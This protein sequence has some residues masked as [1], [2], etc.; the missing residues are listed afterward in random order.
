MSLNNPLPGVVFEED[1][2]ALGAGQVGGLS[3]T[4]II[5]TANKGDLL[6]SEPI[7]SVNRLE[8][9]F[10]TEDIWDMSGAPTPLGLVRGCK[11]HLKHANEIF[12]IRVASS[13]ASKASYIVIPDKQQYQEITGINAE[14]TYT[15]KAIPDDLGANF[16]ASVDVDGTPAVAVEYDSDSPGADNVALITSAHVGSALPGEIILGANLLAL[17]SGGEIIKVTFYINTTDIQI[18]TLT[19]KSEGTWGQDI[20]LWVE[21]STEQATVEDQSI[22]GAT[23]VV[24]GVA[25]LRYDD[26][27]KSVIN[28]FYMENKTDG[29]DTRPFN[30][31]YYSSDLI[32]YAGELTQSDNLAV[33]NDRV[34][35]VFKVIDAISIE[36]I[37]VRIKGDTAVLTDDVTVEIFA[38]NADEEPTGSA[39]LSL[40][41]D[42][43]D[44]DNTWQNIE[45]VL[46]ATGNELDL[47]ANTKYALVVSQPGTTDVYNIQ[48]VD[49]HV[50]D[51]PHYYTDGNYLNSTD[52]GTT[53]LD[54]NKENSLIFAVRAILTSGQIA[55]MSKSWGDPTNLA[56]TA[57]IFLNSID[58]AV[59]TSYDIHARYKVNPN[60]N[61]HKLIVMLGDYREEYIVLSG[62]DLA[63]DV[64]RES[65]ILDATEDTINY[66]L[67]PSTVN[68]GSEK[69]PERL[70]GG[71]NG[72]EADPAD[73]LEALEIAKTVEGAYFVVIASAGRWNQSD[74]L[75][76][77]HVNL[78]AHVRLMTE[79]GF[80]RKAMCGMRARG[81]G[82]TFGDYVDEIA[83]RLDTIADPNGRLD[84]VGHGIEIT[85]ESPQAIESTVVLPGAMNACL[86]T[87]AFA[88][89]PENRNTTRKTINGVIDLEFEVGYEEKLA[90]VN[91]G[92]V[93]Y[94]KA[95]GIRV[96]RGVSTD[97]FK[98]FFD[99]NL[100]RTV[101]SIYSRKRAIVVPLVN[102]LNEDE[103]W[104][105]VDGKLNDLFR[106]LVVTKYITKN[107]SIEVSSTRD[108][109]NRGLV[110][111]N[112]FFEPLKPVNKFHVISKI[113]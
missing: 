104:D 99:G 102:E 78:L 95:G 55:V 109:Q 94:E 76:A 4:I 72:S 19:A 7:S 30:P 28:F 49:Y 97:P 32:F 21:P 87:G 6:K 112:D 36:S 85:D 84:F 61:V 38:V 63:R 80:E 89:I 96:V 64:N 17:I 2:R 57:R 41:I 90:M 53:W 68:N 83:S 14:D 74:D 3:A 50:S 66:L 79:R 18:A 10:G 82:E 70:T 20:N 108:Q 65:A 11:L 77:L 60:S 33:A 75:L 107:Y 29:N 56:N 93:V 44:M 69:A 47:S 113:G 45:L 101:D 71:N 103:L 5:G 8:E 12:A 111:V 88:S 46:S 106:E 58:E 1:L 51:N 48:A 25:Q 26:V 34:A 52:G 15:L 81:S 54:T 92:V 24:S 73:Y 31:L 86:Y 59:I 37:I 40:T 67:F 27:P 42:A 13:S 105:I 110:Q 35:Q 16:V 43:G 9:I 62:R 39:L 22:D 98:R 91:I 23:E 100:R